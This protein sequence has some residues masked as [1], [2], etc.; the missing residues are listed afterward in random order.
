MTDLRSYRLNKVAF[1][2][3]SEDLDFRVSA[4]KHSLPL[5]I[6]IRGYTLFLH[7]IRDLAV[8]RADLR[9][10][11]FAITRTRGESQLRVLTYLSAANPQ[12]RR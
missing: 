5:N 1:K 9:T 8:L 3:R 10:L 7:F 6:Y 12:L 2:F 11:R 4:L